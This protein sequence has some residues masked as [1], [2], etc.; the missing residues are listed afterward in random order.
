MSFVEGILARLYGDDIVG[1][2][3]GELKLKPPD[4][5]TLK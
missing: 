2:L 5:L 3:N 4:Q 1:K